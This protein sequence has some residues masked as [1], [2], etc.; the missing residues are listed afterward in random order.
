MNG[1]EL[2]DLVA[3]VGFPEGNVVHG[4]LQVGVPQRLHDGEVLPSEFRRTSEVEAWGECRDVVK[5][6]IDATA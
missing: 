1:V 4:H 3:D 6:E 2:L 5:L